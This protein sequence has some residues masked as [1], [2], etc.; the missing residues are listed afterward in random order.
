MNLNSS[1]VG[2]ISSAIIINSTPP[3]TPDK[4]IPINPK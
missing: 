2:G 1:V 4:D 3:T